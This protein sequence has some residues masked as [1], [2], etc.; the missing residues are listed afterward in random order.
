MQTLY[1]FSFKV[2]QFMVYTN[3]CLTASAENILLSNKIKAN[4]KLQTQ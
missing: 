2:Q 4:V 3:H 1:S